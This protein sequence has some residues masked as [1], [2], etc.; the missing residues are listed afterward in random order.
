MSDLFLNQVF[1]TT[2]NAWLIAHAIKFV[3]RTITTENKS[4]L[5]FFESGG[6]PSAHTALVATLFFSLGFEEGWESNFTVIAGVLAVIVMYDALNVRYRAGEHA[7]VLNKLNSQMQEKLFKKPLKENLG[8]TYV[9]V[10]G[11]I[12]LAL[13]VS[14]IS[15]VVL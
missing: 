12:I 14:V 3:Y 8:H 9:E 13:I 15:Y 2:W 11:G 1:I 6:F 5:A 7:K 10:A 4:F